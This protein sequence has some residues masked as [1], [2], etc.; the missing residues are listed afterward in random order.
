MSEA[1]NKA[2]RA[3]LLIYLARV[4][5]AAE[6][7]KFSFA[8]S[9]ISIFVS[10][11]DLGL[12]SIITRE[13]SKEKVAKKEFSSLF[14]L[15]VFLGVST[16]VLVF[17]TS[18]F[19]TAD[20]GIR[21]VIWV[22]AV[23]SFITQFPELLYAF[24]RAQQRMEYEAWSNIFIVV[25]MVGFVF[26]VIFTRPSLEN[27]SYAYLLSG[28]FSVSLLFLIF[29]ARF[30]PL[31]FN[32]EPADWMK[33]L[34][35]SWPLA[36]TSIS[37]VLYSYI[38]SIIMGY[39]KQMSQTGWYNAS[40]K[41]VYLLSGPASIITLNF[42]PILSKFSHESRERF[43]NAWNYQMGIMIFLAAPIVVVGSILADKIIQFFY[44]SAYYPSVMVLQILVFMS[45]LSFLSCPFGNALVAA[46]QQKK[47]FFI[48][49]SG[50]ATNIILNLILIPKYSLY[51][52]AFSSVISY[53]VMLYFYFRA[54]AVCTVIKPLNRH[55]LW[56]VIAVII[57]AAVM[58]L[59]IV[60]PAVY[61]LNLILT[62][63][64]GI[65]LYILTFF[66]AVRVIHAVTKIKVI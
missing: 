50:A 12:S 44:G 66:G 65:C 40:L 29:S 54:T 43:Q 18:F 5:G 25:T 21:R 60:S 56:F 19:I 33:F 62:V 15:K 22:L 47:T 9:F 10:F 23:F 49:I 13:F 46:N 48:S 58:A 36:L 37:G 41:I 57:A 51:G 4:L 26:F 14:T 35:M 42:L 61:N 32:V 53:L 20:P 1:F 30:I 45:G 6:Y 38:D 24:W 7:G 11:L 59:L 31:R 2:I 16:F 55:I 3:V 27:I 63:L 28:L 64:A 39:L 17:L 8:L 34:S 52:A